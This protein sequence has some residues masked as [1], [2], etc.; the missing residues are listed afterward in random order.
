MVKNPLRKRVF[1][2]LRGDFGNYAV[3]FLLLTFTI[4]F[5]SGFLVAD[6]STIRAYNEGFEKYNIGNGNFRVKT[7]LNKAQ[8]R[9]I[10]ESGVTLLT[11]A[12]RLKAAREAAAG[13]AAALEH[14]RA[15]EEMLETMKKRSFFR[16]SG[17]RIWWRPPMFPA[18]SRA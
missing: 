3:I 11:L 12:G 8:R 1:R 6:G 2:E 13:N 5:V 9:I 4:A 10:E 14:L 17:R 7:K 18:R 15:A 16:S